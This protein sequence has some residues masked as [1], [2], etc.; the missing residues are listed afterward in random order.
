MY[1]SYDIEIYDDLVDGQT[2]DLK[3]IRPSVAAICASKEDL[4]Y[5]YDIPFMT[6]EKAIILVNCL[7]S[8]IKDGLIPFTWNGTAFDWPLLAYYSG[9][10]DECSELALN[11]VDGMLLV[12]FNKGFF[13]SLDAALLGAG[14][15]TKTHSV[16]LNNGLVFSEMSGKLAP[17]MWR[18]G[19]YEAVKT[20][21]AGDVFR[22]LELVSAIEKNRGIRWTSRAGKAN[23]LMTGLTQVKD[24]FKLPLPDCSWMSIQ[25]KPRFEFVEWIPKEILEKYGINP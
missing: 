7:T 3:T 14:L 25:P 9:M 10:I 5:F 21:L 13:L 1:V 17:K 2:P 8:S 24:L 11:S 23:F 19:E 22:P 16:T 20:Y 12:T 4:R 6:K 18:D 15:E